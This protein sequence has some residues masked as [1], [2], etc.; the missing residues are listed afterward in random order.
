MRSKIIL[1]DFDYTLFNVYK[2]LKNIN[3]SVP[4]DE[5]YSAY[6]YKDA[7]DFI[8]YSKKYGVS[9]IFSEGDIEF[10]KL[11]IEKT[12]IAKIFGKNLKIYGSY[13]KMSDAENEFRGKE[14]LLVDDNPSTVIKAKKI[15]WKV[16]RVRRGKYRKEANKIAPDYTVNNLGSIITMNL[17]A[18]L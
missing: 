17:L 3:R 1:I 14:V 15:G 8:K 18:K 5:D 10:Q 4:K 2:Y 12:G 9:Y 11:K 7:L 16:I 6:L 13:A